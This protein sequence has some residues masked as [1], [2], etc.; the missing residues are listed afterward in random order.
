MRVLLVVPVL[1]AMQDL[2]VTIIVFLFLISPLGSQSCVNCK[3]SKLYY[4]MFGGYLLIQ[5]VAIIFSVK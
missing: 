1:L 3:E 5:A 4:L 2:E